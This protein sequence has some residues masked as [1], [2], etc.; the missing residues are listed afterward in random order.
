MADRSAYELLGV[1]SS[2]SQDEIRAA[3]RRLARQMHPDV[4]GSAAV[5]G[6]I[7][8]AY[9]QIGDPTRRR[10]Y[11]YASRLGREG[12]PRAPSDFTRSGPSS[13]GPS[14]SS[15][16]R[17]TDD[18]GGN[19]GARRAAGD[20]AAAGMSNGTH[21]NPPSSRT[22][23]GGLHRNIRVVTS[24]LVLAAIAI[25]LVSWQLNS[26]QKP[27]AT[28]FQTHKTQ[29]AS[30]AQTAPVVAQSYSAPPSVTEKYRHTPKRRA[31]RLPRAKRLLA[32]PKP[33]VRPCALFRRVH[34]SYVLAS[35]RV[36]EADETDYWPRVTVV[37]DSSASVTIAVKGNGVAANPQFPSMPLRM[38]WGIDDGP[39][40]VAAQ[41]SKTT[42]LGKR[43]GEVL[44]S[45]DGGAIRTVRLRARG[46]TFAGA[47]DG[48]S[49][50]CAIRVTRDG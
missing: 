11:D 3:Y 16:S 23:R 18:V 9:E 37:N 26:P 34:V 10:A 43:Y 39:I 7:T 21:E 6:L 13:H 30:A 27:V 29:S 49:G 45:F 8:D 25:A 46:A 42:D 1:S 36:P 32:A 24:V 44:A 19:A 35:A 17:P 38:S 22:T 31:L 50:S 41:H 48:S 28:D 5:F 15:R 4:G 40:R 47:G 14:N 33:V 20:R 2:A 12:P